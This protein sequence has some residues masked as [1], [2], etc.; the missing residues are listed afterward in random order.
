MM[1]KMPGL[2]HDKSAFALVYVS[3]RVSVSLNTGVRNTSTRCFIPRSRDRQ[4]VYLKK[5]ANQHRI[6][7][8]LESIQHMEN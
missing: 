5:L 7:V 4:Y 3:H 1:L 6:G 8:P 2:V